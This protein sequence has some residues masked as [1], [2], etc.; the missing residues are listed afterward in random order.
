MELGVRG[1][2][3]MVPMGAV[4]LGVTENSALVQPGAFAQSVVAAQAV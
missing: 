1:R 3:T 2:L 4:E